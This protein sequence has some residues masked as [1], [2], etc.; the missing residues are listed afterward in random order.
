MSEAL[1]TGVRIRLLLRS[2]MSMACAAGAEA[3]VSYT[4]CDAAWRA[5]LL[6]NT[7]LA[8]SHIHF[9]M[10]ALEALQSILARKYLV[11]PCI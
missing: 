9:R 4:P 1:P 7:L 3:D 11:V 10:F 6:V 5:S 8:H 2:L